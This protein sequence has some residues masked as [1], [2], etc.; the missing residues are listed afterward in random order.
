MAKFSIRITA[1]NAVQIFEKGKD[2]PVILQPTW[3]NGASFTSEAEARSWGKIALD[4]LNGVEGDEVP[5]SSPNNPIRLVSELPEP[6]E[7]AEEVEVV[8]FTPEVVE[9]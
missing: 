4:R 5:G 3:P 2:A 8:E 9:D 7:P 1:E 6:V